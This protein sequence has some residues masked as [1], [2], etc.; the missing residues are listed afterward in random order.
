MTTIAW[1]GKTLAADKRLDLNGLVV[2][3]TKIARHNNI[4]I[5]AAGYIASTQAL[6]NWIIKGANE[7]DFPKSQS[8]DQRWCS[9]IVVIDNKIFAYEM[10]PYPFEIHDKFYAIGSGRDYAISAMHF[11]KSAIEAVQFASI[12]NLGTGSEVDSLTL[13]DSVDN[14]KTEQQ[15][16]PMIFDPATGLGII[17][18]NIADEYRKWHGNKA[19]LYNPWTGEPRD[20]RDIASNVFGQ[21]IIPPGEPVYAG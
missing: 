14:K 10:T 6:I 21:L 3:T 20:P 7:N 12:F 13:Q 18:I 17:G 19:W 16:L 15:H 8:D 1:D 2:S 4:L 9:N 5:G 11:G